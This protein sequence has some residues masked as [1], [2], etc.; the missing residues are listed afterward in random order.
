MNTESESI[1]KLSEVAYYEFH[2]RWDEAKAISHY[3]YRYF[4]EYNMACEELEKWD[5]FYSSRYFSWF[6]STALMI[7]LIV[8]IASFWND[9][10]WLEQPIRGGALICIAWF[11]IYCI[12]DWFM[13]ITLT[14]YRKIIDELSLKLSMVVSGVSLWELKGIL[15]DEPEKYDEWLA[16]VKSKLEN[17][18]QQY[19]TYKIVD[20]DFVN[21]K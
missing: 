11:L 18:V 4:M 3:S 8:W 7:G 10:I 1:G 17:Q 12:G 21:L 9:D 2:R 19:K 16:S 6:I 20:E 5:K 15:K 13:Q 14:K